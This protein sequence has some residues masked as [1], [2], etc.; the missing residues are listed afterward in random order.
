MTPLWAWNK[1]SN[2]QW[3]LE[4]ATSAFQLKVGDDGRCLYASSQVTLA[5]C[6]GAD[7][8]FQWRL[9]KKYGQTGGFSVINNGNGNCL[10]AR[11]GSPVRMEKCVSAA[12]QTWNFGTLPD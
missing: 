4:G 12:N 8:L 7:S 1:H 10:T 3:S 2:Q 6:N 9:V 11:T 5:G